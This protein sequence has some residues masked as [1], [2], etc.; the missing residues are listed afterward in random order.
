ML[1]GNECC[2][3][4]AFYRKA[5]KERT[6]PHLCFFHPPILEGWEEGVPILSRPVG[7]FKETMPACSEF[8]PRVQ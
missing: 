3:Q 7:E 5:G 6:A 1:S 2:G 4:C 8:K